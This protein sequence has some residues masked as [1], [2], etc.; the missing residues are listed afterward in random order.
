MTWQKEIEKNNVK[1]KA[2]AIEYFRYYESYKVLA[3]KFNTS[4][5]F[6]GAAIKKH[7]N[8]RKTLI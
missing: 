6:V 1:K 7:W 4:A 2:I 3:D 5:Q 8:E